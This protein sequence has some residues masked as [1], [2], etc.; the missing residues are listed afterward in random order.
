MVPG[1]SL[2]TQDRLRPLSLPSPP[3]DIPRPKTD[4]SGLN[5]WGCPD[6]YFESQ[7]CLKCN[8][9]GRSYLTEK[10]N[11]R[12]AYKELR[13]GMLGTGQRQYSRLLTQYFE[14]CLDLFCNHERVEEYGKK[15]AFYVKEIRNRILAPEYFL[16]RKA[17]FDL[18]RQAKEAGDLRAAIRLQKELIFLVMI[19]ATG[20][21]YPG[22]S[23][24]K[25]PDVRVEARIYNHV[26]ELRRLMAL[27]AEGDSK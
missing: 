11:S 20:K 27:K 24:Q 2:W 17:L 23:I 18:I 9:C 4:V 22:D 26:Q 5:W 3:D 16:L 13:K 8:E 14:E 19:E 15:F 6:M 7:E 25:I 12:E 21:E 10:N 1:V